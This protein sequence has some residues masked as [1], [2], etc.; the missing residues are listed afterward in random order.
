MISLLLAKVFIPDEG[1]S[2]INS[3]L[4]EY[5]LH[6]HTHMHSYEFVSVYAHVIV[7]NFF[8][9]FKYN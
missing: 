5:R 6:E 7:L 4:L 9:L 3:P 2:D 8:I 1:P